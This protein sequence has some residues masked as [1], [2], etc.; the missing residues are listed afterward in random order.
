MHLCLGLLFLLV[1]LQY[2]S[3]GLHTLLSPLTGSLG[4]STLG[5]HLVLENLLTRL[6]GLGLVD[7]HVMS[8]YLHVEIEGDATYVLNKGTLVLEGVTLGQVV[9]LVV[10]VL[11]DLAAGPVLDQQTAE[12]SQ[13]AHPEDLA[14]AIVNDMLP[15]H[16]TSNFRRTLAF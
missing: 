10:E 6:L 16:S 9:E 5:V 7:L 11:V 8:V 4:L 13:A 1:A 14:V 3:L 12:D 2:L 15:D